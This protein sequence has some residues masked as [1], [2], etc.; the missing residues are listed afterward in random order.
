MRRVIVILFATVALVLG[1]A[2]A[3]PARAGGHATRLCSGE[4]VHWDTG[5]NYSILGFHDYGEAHFTANP[6][7]CSYLKTQILCL[8]SQAENYYT[9]TSSVYRGVGVN[10][11]LACDLDDPGER[12]SL[13][14][15]GHW[16]ELCTAGGTPA[17]RW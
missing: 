11:K 10:D 3:A 2:Y 15:N 8:N 13:D 12:F 5:I 16:R 17:C 14:L 4:K 6:G 9:K 7:R 1:A